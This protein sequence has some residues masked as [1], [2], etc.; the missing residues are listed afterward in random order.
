MGVLPAMELSLMVE[1][2]IT[3][4]NI[5]EIVS[6][7]VGGITVFVTLRNTV[8]N[9]KTQV[10]GMQT[11][12]KKLGEILIAQADIRAELRSVDRRVSAT[13][14]DIRDLRKGRGFI[15]GDRG[16]DGEYPRP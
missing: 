15:Q 9:I 7:I 8:A 13:E 1:Q 14:Q 6:I 10:D 11:E 4:G 3:I 5:I 12:I 16:V 2:T